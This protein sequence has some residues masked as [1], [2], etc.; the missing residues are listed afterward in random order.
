M[1][2]W[3]EAVII[4]FITCDIIL[5]NFYEIRNF[6]IYYYKNIKNKAKEIFNELFK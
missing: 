6:Y 2:R 5:E 1:N 3:E 4:G